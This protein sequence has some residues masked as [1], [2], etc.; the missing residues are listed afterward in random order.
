MMMLTAKI[1]DPHQHH[2]RHHI[3]IIKSI[4]SLS[5]YIIIYQHHHRVQWENKTTK[6]WL[7]V[8]SPS[9]IQKNIVG[10]ILMHQTNVHRRSPGMKTTVGHMKPKSKKL[11][12][13]V[14]QL[15]LWA[16]SNSKL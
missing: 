8:V 3:T 9:Y 13:W 2:H 11:P 5:T 16:I 4:K 14:N 12:S 6:R 7:M 15:F 1:I 10:L